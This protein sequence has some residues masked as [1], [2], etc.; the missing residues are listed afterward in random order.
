MKLTIGQKAA[1][2][3]VAILIVD[4]AIKIWIKTHMMLGESYSIFGSWSYIHFTENYGMAFGIEFWGKFGKILLS[5]FR[6]GAVVAIGFYIRHLIRTQKATNGA[7]IG[8][9]LIMAGALGNIID[10]AFYGLIFNHSMGQVAQLFPEGGG[11]ASFL[12]GQ[13]VDMFYF[14]LIEGHFPSWF[15]IWGGQD[16]VFFRPV[17]NF[18]DAAISCGV[19]YILL[20]QRKLF[21]QD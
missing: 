5:L 16:F 4:Q 7:V 8:L 9:A 19:I 20:F 14:P 11:Y 15:P 18:A 2:I 17:F 12:H 13:V 10:S 6:V 1:L 21:A 3:V